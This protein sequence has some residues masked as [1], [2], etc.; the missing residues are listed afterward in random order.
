MTRCLLGERRMNHYHL[1]LLCSFAPWT[2]TAV[3]IVDPLTNAWDTAALGGFAGGCC[4]W[5]TI[6]YADITGKLYI[7]PQVRHV[8]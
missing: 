2:S 5:G 1:N 7:S 3:L 8:S 4:K 6:A